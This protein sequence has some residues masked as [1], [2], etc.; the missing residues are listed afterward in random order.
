MQKEGAE[1]VTLARISRPWGNKGDVAAENLA[2]GLRHFEPGA[3]LDVRLP[4]RTLL[5]LEL[6]RAREH[7]GRVILGF[8]GYATISDAERLRGAE[9]R[10]EKGGL[11]PLPDGE[12]YIDDLIGCSMVDDATERSLG[13]VEEVY[14]PPGGV[15][16]F[17]VVDE[18][19]RG[20]YRSTF[21]DEAGEEMLVPF[22]APICRDVDLDSGRIRVTLPE[23][24]EDLKA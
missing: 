22:A 14:E 2:G 20:F 1:Y 21:V 3:R 15:L 16:L 17:S 7:K 5:E 10:C 23:G 19:L 18:Q 6:V 12:Y 4:N 9:V 24:M 13:R 11:E 8:A